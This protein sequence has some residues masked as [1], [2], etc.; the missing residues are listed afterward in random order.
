MKVDNCINY[1]RS[2]LYPRSCILCGAKGDFEHHL[3]RPCQN[4]LPFNYHAC[5]CCALPLP[6]HVP[7]TQWCGRCIRRQPPFTNS[8]TALTYEPPVNR[9]IG[10]LKFQQKLHLAEPLAGLLVERLSEKHEQPDILLPVPL[11]P[12]RL[13]A[14]GFNQSVE[15]T[16]VVSRQCR[17]PFDWRL[18]RRV[19]ETK[20]QSELNEQERHR[21][22]HNAFQVCADVKGAHLALVDD[23]ITTGATVTELSKIL[24]R[25]GA[26]RVDVWAVARTPKS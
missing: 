19:K 18:C 13:R 9:L 4:S 14:R 5:P 6:P 22:L 15:I 7:S 16:R 17:L 24:I 21:N 25:A 12:L 1:V 26:E 11:H 2:L 10:M 23:V 3:C 8:L 20:A